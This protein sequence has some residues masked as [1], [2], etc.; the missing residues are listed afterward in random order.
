VSRPGALVRAIAVDG[1]PVGVLRVQ[2]DEPVPYLVRCMVDAAW[3]GR[4]IG[5]RAVGLLLDEWRT[6]GHVELELSY[7]PGE[8]GAEP[9]RLSCDFQSTGRTHGGE[10]IMRMDL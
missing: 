3:Q 10:V 8:D 4:G 7:V 6:A 2:T 1:R 9:F 5:Q